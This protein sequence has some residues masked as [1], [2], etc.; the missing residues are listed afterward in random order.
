MLWP[1]INVALSIFCFGLY[2]CQNAVTKLFLNQSIFFSCH[3][4]ALDCHQSKENM[5]YNNSIKGILKQ[6]NYLKYMSFAGW[7]IL[8]YNKVSI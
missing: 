8:I 3:L 4:Y 2:K 7:I 1:D 6:R 5:D